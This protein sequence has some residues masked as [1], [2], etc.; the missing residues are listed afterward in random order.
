MS[1]DLPTLGFRTRMLTLRLPGECL[2]V[3]KQEVC[4]PWIGK[5]AKCAERER[6]QESC[7]Q[8]SISAW[9]TL[10]SLLQGM[11]AA[12]NYYSVSEKALGVS[13]NSCYNREGAHGLS[14]FS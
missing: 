12:Q 9:Y 11:F 3:K 4:G 13:Q 1:Q 14:P 2:I 8:F 5:N 10:F 6:P 7:V